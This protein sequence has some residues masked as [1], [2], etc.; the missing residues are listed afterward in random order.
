MET[1]NNTNSLILVV[2]IELSLDVQVLYIYIYIYMYMYVY[3]L[4]VFLHNSI[5]PKKRNF[6]FSLSQ[7]TLIFCADPKVFIAIFR[8]TVKVSFVFLQKC[9]KKS[10]K[11][12]KFPTY[13]PYF[14]QQ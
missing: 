5:R 12:K 11:I 10:D 4:I 13:Q 8:Q 3:N 1:Y 2:Y 14:F 7:P 6:V 9:F